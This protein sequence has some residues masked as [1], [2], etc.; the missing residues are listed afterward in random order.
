MSDVGLPPSFGYFIFGML[1]MILVGAY[2][3]GSIPFGYFIA[4]VFYHTDIRK[5]SSANAGARGAPLTIGRRG[6]VAVLI[7]DAAKGFAPVLIVRA[8]T[9]P[10]GDPIFDWF[11]ASVAAATV[12]GYCFSPWRRVNGGKGVATSFGAVLGLCWPAGL[13]AIAVWIAG[14]MLTRY[15]PVGSMLGSLVMPVAIWLFTKSPALTLYGVF[16]ALLIVFIHRE[17]IR[18]LGAGTEVPVKLFNG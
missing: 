10:L 14:T 4:R 3:I 7:L 17:N 18:R 5:S 2:L 11:V 6:M 15:P 12:L 16:A 1:A 9:Q 8:F 13:V